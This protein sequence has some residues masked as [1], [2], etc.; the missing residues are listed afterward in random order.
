MPS[1]PQMAAFHKFCQQVS[2]SVLEQISPRE[3]VAG[4]LS[5]DQAWEQ[6]ERKLNHLFLVYLLIAWS[7]SRSSLRAVCDRLLRPLR[8]PR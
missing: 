1:I 4:L 8:A 2:F 7:L 3:V 6:R 5:Q